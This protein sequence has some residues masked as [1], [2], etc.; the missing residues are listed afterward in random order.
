MESRFHFLVSSVLSFTSFYFGD[1]PL[2][3]A[4]FC[5]GWL[6]DADHEIDYRILTGRF[7]LNPLSL[8]NELGGHLHSN[9]QDRM[10]CP[11]HALEWLVIGIIL[12]LPS[13]LLTS[14]GLHLLMDIIGSGNFPQYSSLILRWRKRWIVKRWRD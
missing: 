10:F 3:L 5:V 1:F 13:L 7:A 12:K 11:L 2:S 4:V 9:T 14:Y 6:I 8:G